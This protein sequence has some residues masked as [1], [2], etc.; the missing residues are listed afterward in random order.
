VGGFD[1]RYFMYFEDADISRKFQ[2]LGYR[3]VCYPHVAVVHTWERA[4]HKSLRMALVLI[5]N[6]YRFFSKWGWR[7]Y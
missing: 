1:A 2:R 4:S 3:T 6:G 7:L 5:A